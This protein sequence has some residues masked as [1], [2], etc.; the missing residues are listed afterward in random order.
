M[1]FDLEIIVRMVHMQAE[2]EERKFLELVAVESGLPYSCALNQDLHLKEVTFDALYY[3]GTGL[4][5][6]F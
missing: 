3:I 4:P 5:L 2:R 1:S 6:D